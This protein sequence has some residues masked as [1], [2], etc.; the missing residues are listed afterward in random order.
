MKSHEGRYGTHGQK[1]GVKSSK[2]VPPVPAWNARRTY[3]IC[4]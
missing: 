2:P 3:L 4:R 1:T